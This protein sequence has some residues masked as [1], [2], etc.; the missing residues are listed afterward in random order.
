M[1]RQKKEA[2]CGCSG[3]EKPTMRRHRR[4]VILGVLALSAALLPSC[5]WDM[6][7]LSHEGG[8]WRWSLQKAD[9]TLYGVWG[10]GASDVFAVGERGTI[11]HYNGT[12]WSAMTSG[13]QVTLRDVQG[14][15]DIF[16]VGDSGTILRYDGWTWNPMSS[17]TTRT[18]HSVWS[19]GSEVVAVG[20]SGTIL[21]YDGIAWGPMTS[22]TTVTLRDVCGQYAVGDG[23]T[24]LHFSGSTWGTV[25]SGTTTR[26]RGVLDEASISYFSDVFAVGDKG[27][28]RHYDGSRWDG[29]PSGTQEVLHGVSGGG[30]TA[31][32]VGRGGTA[33]FYVNRNSGGEWMSRPGP[34]KAELWDAWRCRDCEEGRVFVVGARVILE[35]WW[36]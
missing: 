3:R 25:S 29:M 24:V 16:A 1:I 7:A 21:L 15:T 31:V 12:Q 8:G 5:D 33:L 26:L 11:L 36:E 4:A 19:W 17:G 9:V 10:R 2:R 18:L 13:T 6:G 35:G 27:T 22:P 14:Y 23:G 20:D 30:G 28:I 32:A 34:T